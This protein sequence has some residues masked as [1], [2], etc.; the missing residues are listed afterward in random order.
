MRRCWMVRIVMAS[1]GRVLTSASTAS[2]VMQSFRLENFYTEIVVLAMFAFY[3]VNF[4]VG[5]NRNNEIAKAWTQANHQLMD[6][7]FSYVGDGKGHLLIKDSQSDY[8]FYASGRVNCRSL[9]TKLTVRL[10][11]ARFH[12][13]NED[14]SLGHGSSSIATNWSRTCLR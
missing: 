4:L 12:R 10:L 6:S 14:Y 1:G 11:C 8:I 13:S 7:N 3:L 5:R 2:S 9:T